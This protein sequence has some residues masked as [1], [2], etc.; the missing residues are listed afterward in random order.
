MKITVVLIFI[1]F[2]VIAVLLI[3]YFT[4]QPTRPQCY[5]LYLGQN[6]SSNQIDAA[7]K[8]Y[9]QKPCTILIFVGWL[10]RPFKTLI[11]P[12]NTIKDAGAIPV[13][14]LEPWT[15]PIKDMS[16]EEETLKEFGS[17]LKEY[18]SPVF[19]R[20]AHEMNGNWYPWSG[21]Q[22]QKQS[23]LYIDTWRKVHDAITK[24]SGNTKIYWIWSINAEDVPSETWNKPKNY[25]PGDEYVNMIGIDGYNFKSK[26]FEKIFRKQ[27]KYVKNN[28][29]DKTIYITE[30][31]SST[32]EVN[33]S[34]WIKNFFYAFSRKYS[35]IPMFIWFDINKEAP[36]NLN[37]ENSSIDAFKTGLKDLIPKEPQ[38]LLEENKK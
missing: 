30:M 25:Y 15:F 31:A 18:N 20:F 13:I 11:P 21:Y 4:A 33:R 14:T 7:S 34:K 8:T 26:K 22:N 27:I 35:Y 2:A 1:V 23:A 24:Y 36:W 32:S 17:M 16:K 37:A 29:K 19:L 10:D 9:G 28:F 12:L 38:T 3:N 6:I 5:G